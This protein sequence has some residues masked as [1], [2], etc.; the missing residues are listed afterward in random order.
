MSIKAR[1]HLAILESWGLQSLLSN[2]VHFCGFTKVP[3]LAPYLLKFKGDRRPIKTYKKLEFTRNTQ[4]NIIS[5]F[6]KH[7]WEPPNDEK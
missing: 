6:L 5:F 1:P 2:G 4:K 7:F 3:F